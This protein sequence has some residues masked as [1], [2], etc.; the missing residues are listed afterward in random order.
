MTTQDKAFRLPRA[1]WPVFLTGLLFLVYAG[2]FGGLS[3]GRI[4]G[5][6]A[7]GYAAELARGAPHANPHHLAFHPLASAIHSALSPFESPTFALRSPLGLAMT[8]QVLL[9]ALG[10]ALAA[11]FFFRA[12]R[13]TL[14]EARGAKVAALTLTA[15]LAFSSGHWLYASVGETYLPAIAAETLLLGLALR[16]RLERQV[17]LVALIATLLAAVLLR[18]DSVLVALPV[19]LLLRPR[20]AALVLASAGALAIAV[21][22]VAWM[23]AGTGDGF[24]VWLRGLANSGLWGAPIS[25]RNLSVGGT[26]ALTTLSYPIWYASQ[27][28]L[29]G[30]V[31]RATASLLMG[32]A[33]WLLLAMGPRL[34]QLGRQ[35]K[36]EGAPALERRRALAALL[37]FA[38]LRFG[39]FAWW[40]P[41]NMEYHTGTLTPLFLALAVWLG[42]RP[43]ATLHAAGAWTFA[44]VL[45][46]AG[47]VTSLIG[48]NQASDLD[49]RA[50]EA[51]EAAGPGGLVLSLDGL[52]HLA[53]ERARGTHA[54]GTADL[55]RIL[56]ASLVASGTN[57]DKL[58]ELRAAIA[59]TLRS[60]G[61]VFAARDMILPERFH[62]APWPLDWTDSH[63]D[64]G[65]DK[66]VDGFAPT[67]V[68]MDAGLDSWLWRLE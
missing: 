59:H 65:M 49:A 23:G 45:V 28:F 27:G 53:L 8:A 10:G 66:L 13:R 18:Q 32:L 41:G 14:G 36:T 19:A 7:I 33:P 2:T 37:S 56:N 55:P 24:T 57:L 20:R 4:L 58:P 64:G 51:L 68:D 16:E 3:D 39:F 38:L 60:G 50:Q 26:L 54:G 31:D 35:G 1:A 43:A 34:G 40:Q 17:P 61:H 11:L 22:V 15:A 44:A 46:I 30:D 21:Y 25:L 48:P 29:H 42:G 67:P 52:G 47:N 12:A 5:N 9:S 6:D 63:H 62:H